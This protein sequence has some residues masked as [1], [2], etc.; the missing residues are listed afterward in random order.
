MDSLRRQLD[1]LPAS[2][3]DPILLA[4]A[5][6]LEQSMS[7]GKSEREAVAELGSPAVC[8][9]RA[10]RGKLPSGGAQPR[11][12]P[13]RGGNP[14]EPR[15]AGAHSLPPRPVRP[16]PRREEE[17]RGKKPWLL[18]IVVTLAALICVGFSV[19]RYLSSDQHLGYAAREE[20]FDAAAV[21]RIVVEDQNRPV[22]VRAL[23]SSDIRVNYY[24]GHHEGYTLTLADGTLTVRS[25]SEG[26]WYD[27]FLTL[28]D[29]TEAVLTI[30]MP[31]DF[32]GELDLQTS[33][34]SIEVENLSQVAALRLRTDN[35]A[36]TVRA[37]S[38]RGDAVLCSA[39]GPVTAEE[40]TCTGNLTL[41]SSNAALTV[42]EVSCTALDLQTSNGMI[43]CTGLS[44]TVQRVTAETSNASV[45]GSIAGEKEEFTI[46]AQTSN[47]RSYLE[48]RS[49]GS[50]ELDISTSN[51]IIDFHFLP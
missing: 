32:S 12:A 39:N 13:S 38:V 11:P 8:A 15:M 14:F 16:E 35:D 10:R 42:A 44:R 47:S 37:V 26:R 28:Y 50:R 21:T 27:R 6:R 24:E 36:I 34:D 4:Y 5:E 40:I 1:D 9:A 23:T 48:N 30:Y 51:G 3:R 29:T 46:R 18:A 25:Q 41:T 19:L 49:G 45:T 2:E 33:N 22:R 43:T 31:P 17:P 20:S 7:A